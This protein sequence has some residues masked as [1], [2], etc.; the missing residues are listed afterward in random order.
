[1]VQKDRK[2]ERGEDNGKQGRLLFWGGGLEE[3][4]TV[5][6]RLWGKN[7]GGS[8]RGSISKR[9]K[10]SADSSPPPRREEKERGKKDN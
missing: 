3:G 1:M 8:V 7:K 2:E 6:N 5:Y 10:I 9:E 4:K